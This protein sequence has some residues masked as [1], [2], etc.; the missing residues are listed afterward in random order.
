MDKVKEKGNRPRFRTRKQLGLKAGEL[1][2]KFR[3][4]INPDDDGETEVSRKRALLR[5]NSQRVYTQ[6][7][8]SVQALGSMRT[9]MR[10]LSRLMENMDEEDQKAALPAVSAASASLSRIDAL[11]REKVEQAVRM[12]E[13][14][15]RARK[16]ARVARVRLA[17]AALE[18][19]RKAKEFGILRLGGE[20]SPASLPAVGDIFEW[21]GPQAG[22]GGPGSAPKE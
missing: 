14:V 4:D 16:D 15:E 12:E 5:L 13:E 22:E 19:A 7:G 18:K 2:F 8:C 3:V 1:P 10:W 11:S 6:M 21:I 9:V 20:S 17:K